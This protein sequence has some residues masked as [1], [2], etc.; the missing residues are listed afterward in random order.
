MAQYPF[1]IDPFSLTQSSDNIS[2]LLFGVLFFLFFLSFR[3][4]VFSSFALFYSTLPFTFKKRE[5]ERKGSIMSQT[6][7]ILQT[8]L[9]E[10]KA[11][12]THLPQVVPH[13]QQEEEVKKKKGNKKKQVVYTN[14]QVLT[15]TRKREKATKSS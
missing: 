2:P 14:T 1:P 12:S 13:Q 7:T 9:D 15:N 3:L 8:Q 5:K 4:C 11:D 6:E 10:P